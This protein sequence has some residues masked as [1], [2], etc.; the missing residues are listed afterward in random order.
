MATIYEFIKDI[1]NWES[2]YIQNAM[3]TITKSCDQIFETCELEF[4]TLSH[5]SEIEVDTQGLDID[6]NFNP[7]GRYD[8]MVLI[9]EHEEKDE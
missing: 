5:K 8:I 9:K 3:L 6:K 1:G 4:C 2:I 7:Y